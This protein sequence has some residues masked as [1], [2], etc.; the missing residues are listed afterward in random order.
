MTGNIEMPRQLLSFEFTECNVI[1]KGSC[2][3]N[4]DIQV[5]QVATP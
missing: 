5:L 1:S 2:N 4:T 3:P